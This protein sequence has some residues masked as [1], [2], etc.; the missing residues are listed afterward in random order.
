MKLIASD[1]KILEPNPII[2]NKNTKPPF[3]FMWIITPKELGNKKLK[4]TSSKSEQIMRY[5]SDVN[6]TPN[7]VLD[8]YFNELNKSGYITIDCEVVNS[9]GL[10]A[11]C[12]KLLSY[13]G[14]IN[15]IILGILSG[16]LGVL[17]YLKK[18]VSKLYF[19]FR[20]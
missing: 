14:I 2:Y 15:A 18:M 10:S 3:K 5:F 1:F 16:I 17:T 12:D 4:I 13:I 11:R 6:G 19:I 9:F 7:E 8:R 20:I